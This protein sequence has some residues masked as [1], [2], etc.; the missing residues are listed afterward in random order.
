MPPLGGSHQNIAM[1][2]GVEK[3]ERYGYPMVKEF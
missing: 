1:M 3:L 2:F